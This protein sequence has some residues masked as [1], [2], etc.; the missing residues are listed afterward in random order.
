MLKTNSYISLKPLGN[1]DKTSY[2][3]RSFYK[4]TITTLRS[5]TTVS[6]PSDIIYIYTY[7]Y[8]G[9]DQGVL[10]DI[11]MRLSWKWEDN[12]DPSYP[13]AP[14]YLQGGCNSERV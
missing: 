7:L 5:R 8:N 3:Q 13:I 2:T 14:E 6:S 12:L 9:G 1:T 11:V 10:D 4:S